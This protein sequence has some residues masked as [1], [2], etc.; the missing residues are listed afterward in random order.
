MFSYI[1]ES[2]AFPFCELFVHILCLVF[3]WVVAFFFYNQ[4]LGVFEPGWP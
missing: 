3:I 2:F 1:Y 4:F